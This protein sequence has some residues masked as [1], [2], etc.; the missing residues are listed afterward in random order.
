MRKL[1][2]I[3][4]L[5]IAWIII[6]PETAIAESRYAQCINSGTFSGSKLRCEGDAAHHLFDD[7]D[8][9]VGSPANLTHTQGPPGGEWTW[10]CSGRPVKC[11]LGDYAGNYW[12][13]ITLGF[14]PPPPQGDLGRLERAIEKLTDTVNSGFQ[15]LEAKLDGT[16]HPPPIPQTPRSQLEIDVSAIRY[17]VASIDR[18]LSHHSH[19]H[20]PYYPPWWC[21][22]DYYW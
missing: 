2:W 8:C 10:S 21:Y 15:R 5:W 20:H 9:S 3:P 14:T 6:S 12:C 7:P 4:V 11:N 19:P 13:D 16:T 1:L 22:C 17:H 18:K